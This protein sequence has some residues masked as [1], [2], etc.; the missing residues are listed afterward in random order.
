MDKAVGSLQKA[1]APNLDTGP[2]LAAGVG[3]PAFMLCLFVVVGSS[4]LCLLAPPTAILGGL[5]FITALF[6][7]PFRRVAGFGVDSSMIL[8][9]EGLMNMPCPGGQS[10]YR[11]PCTAPSFF[12]E[13]SSSSIPIQSPG[14]KWV[15]PTNCTVALTPFESS[16]VCPI[17]KSERSGI[18][19]ENHGSI[20]TSLCLVA[21]S[22]LWPSFVIGFIVWSLLFRAYIGERA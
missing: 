7:L 1:L 8:G 15:L 6:A 20:Y 11:C 2:D 4:T 19:P 22:I 21:S 9:T 16:T 13:A 5:P 12:P 14:A 17:W 18:V 10:K 3:L